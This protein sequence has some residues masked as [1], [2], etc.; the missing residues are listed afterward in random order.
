[1]PRA[2]TANEGKPRREPQNRKSEPAVGGPR[3]RQSDAKKSLH[4]IQSKLFSPTRAVKDKYGSRFS[5]QTNV[6]EGALSPPKEAKT[7]NE[8]RNTLNNQQKTKGDTIHKLQ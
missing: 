3:V 2:E 4:S 7:R 5:Q 1:M 8:P 6:K